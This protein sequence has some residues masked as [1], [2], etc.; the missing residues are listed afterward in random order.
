MDLMRSNLTD[1]QSV[2]P[3]TTTTTTR[4]TT[5]KLLDRDAR[6]KKGWTANARKNLLKLSSAALAKYSSPKK[7]KT[8]NIL[9]QVFK[10]I[11]SN[12]SKVVCS[13]MSCIWCILFCTMSE[14]LN[15]SSISL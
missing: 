14:V 12:L 4:R 7:Y 8:L 15:A 11:R 5:Y 6:G 9:I 10:K 3:T 1:L 2:P 13:V